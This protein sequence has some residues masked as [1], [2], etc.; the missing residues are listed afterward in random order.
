[1]SQAAN[2]N[3]PADE[4]ADVAMRE[5]L[6]LARVRLARVFPRSRLGAVKHGELAGLEA[7]LRALSERV[8]RGAL[9]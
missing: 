8:E 9:E 5:A 7:H 6:E 4:E 2:T 1:M 3:A